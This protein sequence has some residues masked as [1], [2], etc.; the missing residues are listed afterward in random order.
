MGGCSVLIE[1]QRRTLQ[2]QIKSNPSRSNS[3]TQEFAYQ[4]VLRYHIYSFIL[5]ERN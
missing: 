4:N 5:T 1:G 2:L 3:S